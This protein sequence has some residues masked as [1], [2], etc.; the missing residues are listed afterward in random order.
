MSKKILIL[1]A[2]PKNT[3]RL[4]LDQEVR[5]ID[6]GLQR[7]QRR[8]EFIVKQQ[9]AARPVDVRRAMLDFKPNI[10]HFCGH[11]GGLEGIAFEDENGNARL[12]SSEALAGFFELFSDTVDCV[13]L[14][15]CYS[16]T[17][18]EAI[19]QHI[20]YVIGMRKGLGDLAALEF[21]V[22]FYD[23]LG[24]GQTI[25]F[26][27]KLAWNA[28]QW[29]NMPEHLTPVLKS[30]AQIT[31]QPSQP[32]DPNY[33]ASLSSL[34]SAPR[35]SEASK[36]FLQPPGD[37]EPVSLSSSINFE[38]KSIEV[39]DVIAQTTYSLIQKCKIKDEQYALKRTQRELCQEGALIKMVGNSF[40]GFDSGAHI[41][42]I[43]ASPLAV[44]VTEDYVW[45]LYPFYEGISLEKIIKHNKYRPSGI[46]LGSF[47]NSILNAIK[48]LHQAGI[49]HRDINPSNILML[50]SKS[51]VLL[52]STFC[53]ERGSMQIPIGNSKYT[54]PE[55]ILGQAVVQS[56]WYSIAATLY[57]V[58]NGEPP[59]LDDQEILETGLSNIDTGPYRNASYGLGQELLK[60]LLKQELSERPQ[61]FS[62]IVLEE[63]SHPF[64]GDILGV[65]ECSNS[66]YMLFGRFFCRTVSRDELQ[67]LLSDNQLS[68]S[69]N[70]TSY[71]RRINIYF[72]DPEIRRDVELLLQD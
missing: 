17:Q 9:W 25:E 20:N 61:N 64:L 42:F 38:F 27:Y 45:E 43:V 53:C 54:A 26:A 71:N 13:M 28:I 51:Y 5:E 48:E 32:G 21:A 63:A 44:W 68:S 12:V 58:A 47:Y 49:L 52:D 10:V 31:Q 70:S 18:A 59:R 35:P 8:D 55:Q 30:K 7:A 24:A 1:A 6:E 57:F 3:P 56:E 16:D 41:T 67:K 22:A 2:N 4:R 15:A 29:T 11:G 65:L 37:F 33:S 36:S 39:S 23:A 66:E 50:N 34:Q 14:N 62:Q 60:V 46:Y 19:A 72:R 69:E 40:K